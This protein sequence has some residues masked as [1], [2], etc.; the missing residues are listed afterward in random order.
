MNRK[1]TIIAL[2]TMAKKIAEQHGCSIVTTKGSTNGLWD[3]TDFTGW[4]KT[5]GEYLTEKYGKME[6]THFTAVP[7]EDYDLRKD[8]KVS[9]E[10][11]FSSPQICV[12]TQW[13]KGGFACVEFNPRDKENDTD[14]QMSQITVFKETGIK[15]ARVIMRY[16]RDARK[17]LGEDPLDWKEGE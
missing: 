4:H 2:M 7:F 3:S 11:R 17:E 1:Q 5:M 8:F 6:E 15:F 9:F 16:W 13:G 14:Y 10:Y 12:G